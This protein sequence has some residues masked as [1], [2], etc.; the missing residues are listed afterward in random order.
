MLG[1]LLEKKII[2]QN[3]DAIFKLLDNSTISS[4]DFN[5]WSKL[6]TESQNNKAFLKKMC[7]TKLHPDK[8]KLSEG[9][10]VS[11]L[12]LLIAAP[13]RIRE[14]IIEINKIDPYDIKDLLNIME[15][16]RPN[17]QDRYH[18]SNAIHT[19]LL[20]WQH[21]QRK[22]DETS[23]RLLRTLYPWG[24]LKNFVGS[25]GEQP[26]GHE[27]LN[28]CFKVKNL[29]IRLDTCGS[30]ACLANSIKRI[31]NGIR[32][33]RVMLVLDPSECDASRLVCLPNDRF[34]GDLELTLPNM[35]D[36]NKKWI[37]EV[38]KKLTGGTSNGCSRLFFDR[39]TLSFTTVLYIM[40]QLV[41][42]VHQKLTVTTIYELTIDQ[43]VELEKQEKRTHMTVKWIAP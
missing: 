38:V 37:V 33:L 28:Y 17:L 4:E 8:W 14:L 31:G 30:V 26:E 1:I 20:F 35:T 19:E 9:N 36:E 12:E 22:C 2:A 18:K 21:F 32:N 39:S 41:D 40:M 11:G 43:L 7:E 34:T 5:F 15:K 42:V 25:T 3:L 6:L 10:V 23:D 29:R 27:V 24:H 16:L 13:T